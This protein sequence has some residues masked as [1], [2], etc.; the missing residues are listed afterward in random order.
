VTM[1]E[2]MDEFSKLRVH[3]LV[4]HIKQFGDFPFGEAKVLEDMWG[5]L[6]HFKLDDEFLTGVEEALLFN[7]LLK[8]SEFEDARIASEW[9]S[10]YFEPEHP[11]L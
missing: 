2:R 11:C 4:E 7:E 3:R 9:A 1:T 5:V 6:E 10:I 8:L